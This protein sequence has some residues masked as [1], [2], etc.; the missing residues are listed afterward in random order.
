MPIDRELFVKQT[1][2]QTYFPS[3]I[4]Q[5]SIN[6]RQS[7]DEGVLKAI[8]QPVLVIFTSIKQVEGV[9]AILPAN[10]IVFAR[11]YISKQ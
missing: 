11:Y 7:T 4:L 5:A 9:P 8:E 6:K 1:R 3:K 10:R 2:T